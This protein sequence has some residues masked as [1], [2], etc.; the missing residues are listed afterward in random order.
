MSS[1]DVIEVRR[2]EMSFYLFKI[3]VKVERECIVKRFR[4]IIKIY[5]L[6]YIYLFIDVYYIFGRL[7]KKWII[8]F[9]FEIKYKNF[10]IFEFI[11]I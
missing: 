4:Y 9:I 2:R 3:K 5:F 6:I 10:C 11:I 7:Y 8:W 1:E